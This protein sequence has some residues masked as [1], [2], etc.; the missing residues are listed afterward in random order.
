MLPHSRWR[1]TRP[2]QPTTGTHHTHGHGHS[3]TL[4]RRVLLGEGCNASALEHSFHCLLL[5]FLKLLQALPFQLKEMFS[6]KEDGY[7]PQS[8]LSSGGPF[9]PL[10]QC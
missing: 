6:Q 3:R 9:T 10:P 2:V 7:G 4:W 5:F 8:K 1:V